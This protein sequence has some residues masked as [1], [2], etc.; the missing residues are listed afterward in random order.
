MDAE[1]SPEPEQR[2][3]WLREAVDSLPELEQLVVSM[4]FFGTA[5][6]FRQIAGETGLTLYEVKEVLDAGFAHLR[7]MLQNHPLGQVLAEH[8][9][10]L[11]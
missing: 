2:L 11:P 7:D 10:Q 5:K 9:A 4:R 6:T 8:V 1:A 3:E